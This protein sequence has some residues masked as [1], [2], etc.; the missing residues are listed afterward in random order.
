LKPPFT[1]NS[2]E[3]LYRK[4]MRGVYPK[5]P[6]V[7]SHHLSKIIDLCIKIDPAKRPSAKELLRLIDNKEDVPRTRMSSVN[8]LNTIRVPKNNESWKEGLPKADYET[9]S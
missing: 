9:L 8:L 5:I 2:M 4:V 1:A 6:A 3:G 7:Y